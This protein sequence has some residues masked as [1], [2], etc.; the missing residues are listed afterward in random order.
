MHEYDFSFYNN[1]DAHPMTGTQDA[2]FT[3]KLSTKPHLDNF[4]NNK[5]DYIQVKNLTRG[6]IYHVHKV[7]MMGD[8]VDLYITDDTGREQRLGIFFFE[9]PD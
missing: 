6:N 3:V 5:P 1:M 7:D 2:N 8:A 9:A 4:F